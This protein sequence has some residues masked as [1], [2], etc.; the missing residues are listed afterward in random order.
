MSLIRACSPEDMPAVAGL[1][2]KTFPGR[3]RSAPESLEAYLA[4]LF[5]HHPWYDP[6]LASRV[7]VSPEGAVRGF[8]GVLPL[9]MCF[10]G[11][12][13][14]AAIAGS[15]MVDR[16][17]E[18]PLAGA[19]LLRSFANGPQELSISESANR[20]SENLWQKLGGRTLP[21][22]SLEWLRILRPAG[23]A[24]AFAREWF[25]PAVLLQPLASMIDRVARH[26][27]RNPFGLPGGRGGYEYDTDAGE[28]LLLEQIPRFAESYS[29]RPDW[30][31]SS[32]QWVLA[33]AR[34]KAR[35]G[36]VCRRMVYGKNHAPIGCYVYYGGPHGIARVLQ[37]LARPE[38]IDAVLDSLLTNAFRN[39]SVAVRGGTHPRLMNAL[40]RHGS[41]FFHRSS[42]IVHSADAELLHAIDSGDALVTGLAGEAWTRL[43]GDRFA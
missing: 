12:K 29:V 5:L 17:E 24:L 21:F 11:K 22:E 42:T 33:H 6:E 8:L 32:L 9:R 3:R 4:E 15:L 23:V 34:A 1:F 40:L 20:V 13:I 19:R 30:N 25:A 36:P 16:P 31:R 28:E 41:M 18:N 37:I 43:I 14:R 27:G 7:Y 39:G 35:R 38:C 10:R 2:Q 26:T